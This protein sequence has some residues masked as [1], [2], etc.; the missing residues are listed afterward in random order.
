MEA[1]MT[2]EFPRT[3]PGGELRTFCETQ[4][5]AILDRLYATAL[6]LTRNSTAN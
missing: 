2:Q 1:L 6:R 4:I 5:D 3:G